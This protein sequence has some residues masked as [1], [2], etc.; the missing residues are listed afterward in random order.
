MGQ[1]SG[2]CPWGSV[3]G[4][5]FTE[6]QAWECPD[7]P[8]GVTTRIAKTEDDLRV[9]D[10]L[11]ANAHGT[12]EGVHAR[13]FRPALNFKPTA[14][15]PALAILLMYADGISV[16]TGLI[17]IKDGIG[18]P[19]WGGV[20]SDHRNKRL[21]TALAHA[22]MKYLKDLKDIGVEVDTIW[23]QAMS[24]SIGLFKRIGFEEGEA[25]TFYRG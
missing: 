20:H 13:F 11:A 4:I 25:V 7:L 12:P 23:V 10:T 8:K 21:G 22:R 24:P 17:S 14:D 16:G 9:F 18:R 2:T 15:H 5:T 6:L 3:V 1:R 19:Y